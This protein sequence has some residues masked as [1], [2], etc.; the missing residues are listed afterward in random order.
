M[1]VAPYPLYLEQFSPELRERGF[2][3][4][5]R[6]FVFTGGLRR[7]IGGRQRLAVEFAVGAQR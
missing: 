4:A 1:V 2:H 6:R 5:D 7:Q 3:F